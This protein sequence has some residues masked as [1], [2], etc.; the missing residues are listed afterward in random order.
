MRYKT[1]KQRR[2]YN[3]LCTTD[4]LQK[5]RNQKVACPYCGGSLVL[6]DSSEIETKYTGKFYVCMNY[7]SCDTYCRAKLYNGEWEMLSSPANKGLRLLRSEAHFWFS[8]LIELEICPDKESAYY[9]VSAGLSTFNGRKIHIG[10]CKEYV[11]K[12][13]I[14]ICVNAIY[15]NKDRIEK[16]EGWHHT[17]ADEESRKKMKEFTYITFDYKKN[18]AAEV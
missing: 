11:C 3:S 15:N 8:K 14:K 10:Q 2:V 5:R 4:I 13:I 7:P 16:F 1:A 18:K 9:F 6:K 17:K 12:E